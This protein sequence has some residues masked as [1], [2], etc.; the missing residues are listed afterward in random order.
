VEGFKGRKRLARESKAKSRRPV[1]QNRAEQ[2]NFL[3]LLEEKIGRGQIPKC[4][5][6]FS[7]RQ[8]AALRR[9]AAGFRKL[10]IFD[11]VSSSAVVKILQDLTFGFLIDKPIGGAKRR[12]LVSSFPPRPSEVIGS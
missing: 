6:G 7:A 12:R 9:L 3:F 4:K 5:E 2:K 1:R 10:G 11:K 8:A